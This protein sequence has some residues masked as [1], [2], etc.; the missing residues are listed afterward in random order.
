MTETGAEPTGEQEEIPI[1]EENILRAVSRSMPGASSR[2]E[3]GLDFLCEP[4]AYDRDLPEAIA[5]YNQVLE[6]MVRATVTN[7]TDPRWSRPVLPRDQEG[8]PA[9]PV[10]VPRHRDRD[11]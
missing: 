6:E 8:R 11:R 7:F 2:R 1:E 10:L 5:E 4:I 3:A 9:G